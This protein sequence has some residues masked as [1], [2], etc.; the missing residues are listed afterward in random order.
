MYESVTHN[1]NFGVFVPLGI[2]LLCYFYQKT[3]S[4]FSALLIDGVIIKKEIPD[5]E[6]ILLEADG[7][8]NNSVALWFCIL[9]SVAINIYAY[10]LKT[11]VWH[12]IDGGPVGIYATIFKIVNHFYVF[13]IAWKGVVTI[14]TLRK[15]LNLNITIRPFHPD[16]SGGL[17]AV[18]QIA[19]AVS[20]FMALVVIYVDLFV[21]LRPFLFHKPAFCSL[22]YHLLPDDLSFILLF[23][24]NGSW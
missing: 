15:I 24:G 1:I 16:N 8:F 22:N 19:L 14:I 18:G 5:Y 17:R 7:R 4:G 12:C 13:Y 10:F 6:K 9:A 21:H 11:G 2:L 23:C 20:Y 3:S